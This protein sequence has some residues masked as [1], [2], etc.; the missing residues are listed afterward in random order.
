MYGS[1]FSLFLLT[2]VYLRFRALPGPYIIYILIKVLP[3]I[4]FLLS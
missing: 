2:P 1:A 3:F 4:F